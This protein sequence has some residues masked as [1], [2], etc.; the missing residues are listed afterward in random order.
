MMEKCAH[1]GA[2][3]NIDY[4]HTVPRSEGGTETIALCHACHVKHHSSKGD[5]KRWGKRG[6]QKT[7]Q[8]PL[9]WL[10]NLKQFRDKDWSET[11]YVL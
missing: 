5:F 6:G 4:H 11:Y 10:K 3:C 9:N 7:A 8:N 2:T 1:C